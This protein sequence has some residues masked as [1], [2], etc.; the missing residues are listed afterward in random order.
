MIADCS[1]NAK[2]AMLHGLLTGYI[3]E[4]D[5]DSDLPCHITFDIQT[6]LPDCY[7]KAADLRGWCDA[8]IKSK[9]TETEFARELEIFLEDDHCICDHHMCRVHQG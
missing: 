4:T 3:V 8:W 9:I 7:P 5:D 2:A 1:L 6:S